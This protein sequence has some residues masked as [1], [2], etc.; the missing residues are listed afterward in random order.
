M[1][2]ILALWT[3][4]IL[5]AL[6][7]GIPAASAATVTLTP[8][9]GLAG[10]TI[11]VDDSGWLTDDTKTVSIVELA[12]DVATLASVDGVFTGTFSVPDTSVGVYT[13]RVSD[14]TESVDAALT[15]A[16]EAIEIAV[17]S[18]ADGD[19][20]ADSLAS[21]FSVLE[22]GSPASSLTFAVTGGSGGEYT[23]SFSN[24]PSLGGLVDP[25]TTFALVEG[26]VFSTTDGALTL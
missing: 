11:Q 13:V 22:Y 2:S 24:L 23:L 18:D 7:A 25:T 6:A 14:G 12:T 9:S 17:E 5:L 8:D 4:V 20:L 19:G 26:S 10:E 15:V 21:P 3:P 1:K 16:A